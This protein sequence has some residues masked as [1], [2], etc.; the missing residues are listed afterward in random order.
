MKIL[1]VD[2]AT[3]NCSVAVCLDLTL[4]AETTLFRRQTHSKHLLEM[5]HQTISMAGIKLNEIDAFAV[6]RG[7][8]SFTGLRIGLSCIKGLAYALDKTVV[9]ISSLEILATQAMVTT[10]NNHLLI[11]PILDA[12]K[13]EVYFAG[14]RYLNHK[15]IQVNPE[16]VLSPEKLTLQI[17]G[18]CLFIGDG[19]ILYQDILTN[20]FKNTVYFAS[21]QQNYIRA[22]TIAILAFDRL[23]KGDTDSLSSLVPQYIRKSDAER[24]LSQTIIC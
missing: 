16:M 22:H 14:F 10:N 19:A 23:K 6:T 24:K 12:R 3:Q 4:L 17:D 15:L 20:T 8:G 9:S 2:T 13:K 1:A 21:P 5:I 11:C 18:P 7:P